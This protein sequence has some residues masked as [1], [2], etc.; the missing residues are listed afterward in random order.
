MNK[1]L[2]LPISLFFLGILF[3]GYGLFIGE[4]T[5]GLIVF[6]PFVMSTGLLSFL[7][8]I[9]LFLGML[10][11]FFVASSLPWQKY[12][13]PQDW[14]YEADSMQQSVEKNV[15]TGGVIFIGPIPIVFGSNKKITKYM[16]IASIIIL[17][18]IVLYASLLL[19]E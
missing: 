19:N 7:G 16:I 6:I 11:F 15:E 12:Q 18:F 5:V 4:V 2:F 9:C 13:R 14:Q 10:T 1:W 8:I 17:F 3:L